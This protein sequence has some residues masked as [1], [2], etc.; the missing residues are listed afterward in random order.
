[1]KRIDVNGIK[2]YAY[3]G[4]LDEEKAIGGNY[5]V[6]LKLYYDFQYAA[7]NDSLEDTIDYVIVNKIVEEEMGIRSKLIETVA[8]RIIKRLKQRF[9]GLE[10]AEVSVT[11][12]CPPINGNVDRVTA[13]IEE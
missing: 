11:K 8:L 9:N 3:H 7:V 4:C 2:L 12:I 10:K 5:V 1:M 13:I 6:D